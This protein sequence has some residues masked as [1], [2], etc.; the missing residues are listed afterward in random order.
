MDAFVTR[1]CDRSM[2]RLWGMSGSTTG[3]APLEPE[4]KDRTKAPYANPRGHTQGPP[5][6]KIPDG[7]TDIIIRWSKDEQA[8]KFADILLS[9]LVIGRLR[10]GQKPG[11]ALAAAKDSP[12]ARVLRE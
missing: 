7:E 11:W 9:D 2:A 8:N 12:L 1:T 5:N 10:A 4:W 3:E 6:F